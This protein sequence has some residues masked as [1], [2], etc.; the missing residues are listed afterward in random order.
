[1]LKTSC[2]PCFFAEVQFLT[3]NFV[4]QKL[5]STR[6][7]LSLILNIKVK[8]LKVLNLRNVSK[9]VIETG[10]E[11]TVLEV[12][13]FYCRNVILEQRRTLWTNETSFSSRIALQLPMLSWIHCKYMIQWFLSL[14]MQHSKTEQHSC[15][16]RIA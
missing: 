8:F 7:I 5:P 13:A 4:Y 12:S 2:F 10:Y 6:M 9:R 15:L 16:L 11:M 14:R 3:L 1:M